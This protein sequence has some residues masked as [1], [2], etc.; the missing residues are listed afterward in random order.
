MGFIIAQKETRI[1]QIGAHD[2]KHYDPLFKVLQMFKNKTNIML[3]EPQ[4]NIANI[5]KDNY[6]WHPACVIVEELIGDGNVKDFY[7]IKPEYYK[8]Y[9][10]KSQ[11][12]MSEAY[13]HATGISGS[14][15]QT[16]VKHYEKYFRNKTIDFQAAVDITSYKS[17]TLEELVNKYW[18]NNRV[19]VLSIDAEG[20]DDLILY[21][22]N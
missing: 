16:F 14:D 3:V 12:E 6:N 5:L 17:L 2:G 20:L 19:D 11:H 4:K 1:I 21:H 9:Y 22:N 7:S 8:D 13:I 10:Y 18:Q 15:Y